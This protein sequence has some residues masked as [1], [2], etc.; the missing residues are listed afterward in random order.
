M[1]LLVLHLLHVRWQHDHLLKRWVNIVFSNWIWLPLTTPLLC[2]LK[3]PI[4]RGNTMHLKQRVANLFSK[5]R[6]QMQSIYRYRTA[7]FTLPV[8]SCFD[9]QTK[10]LE[11]KRHVFLFVP[12]HE[13][14]TVRARQV[15]IRD[16][17]MALCSEPT[18][19]GKGFK[20]T[21]SL[22]H[23]LHATWRGSMQN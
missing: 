20:Q 3:S 14:R 9:L 5:D 2:T 19:T 12:S 10:S 7:N 6:P 15:S 16:Q 21:V 17:K 11:L 8:A 1:R 18:L 23:L 4:P 22:L 13:K